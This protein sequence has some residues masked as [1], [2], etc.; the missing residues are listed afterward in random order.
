MFAKLFLIFVLFLVKCEDEIG[1]SFTC[2]VKEVTDGKGIQW[3][4]EN[5]FLFNVMNVLVTC[6]HNTD[7][8]TCNAGFRDGTK[9]Q[10]RIRNMNIF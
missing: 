3:G 4:D 8:F 5:V 10:I 6:N 7:D 1:K 2:D 9:G